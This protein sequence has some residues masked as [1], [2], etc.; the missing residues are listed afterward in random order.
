MYAQS[1][2]TIGSGTSLDIGN[3]TMNVDD[4]DIDGTL[5]GDTGTI[6]VK[7][8]WTN[9]GTFT[10]GT[11]DVNLIDDP[12]QSPTQ[13][14]VTITGNSQF[15]DLSAITG[16]GKEF[17]FGASETQTVTNNITLLGA[18]TPNLLMRST[19]SGEFAF[20]NLLAGGTQSIDLVDVNDHLATGLELSPLPGTN[21]TAGNVSRWL[22]VNSG[23][24]VWINPAG[25]SWHTASNWS[26]NVVPTIVDD[27][28]IPD[29]G[30]IT[31]TYSTG[32]TSINSLST[33]DNV[34]I[35]GGTLNLAAASTIGTGATLA[36]SGG[37]ING[38]GDLTVDGTLNWTLGTMTGTGTT[39]IQIGANLAI[40]GS[41]SKDLAGTRRLINDS[42]TSTM[43][44]PNNTTGNVRMFDAAVFDNQGS[45]VV[46]T[47][48]SDSIVFQGIS[49]T[50]SFDN[51]GTFTRSAG[52][53]EATFSVAFNNTG[54]VDVQT[55]ILRLAGG[56]SSSGSLSGA[57]L[58]IDTVAYTLDAGV[59]FQDIVFS[60]FATVNINS[61]YTATVSTLV[62]IGATVNFNNGS[63][64]ADIG[65]SL[66][67]TGIPQPLVNFSSGSPTPAT[68]TT[69]VI[70]LSGGV[71]TGSDNLSILAGAGNVFTWTLGTM[72]GTGTTTIPIG[73]NLA[74]SGN[75]SKDLAGARR[76]INNSTTSTMDMPNNTTGNVRMF[77]TAVFDNQGSLVVT[78]T[79]SDSIVFLG[80]SGSPSFDNSGTFTRSAGNGEATFSVSFNN[81]GT[82][83]AQEGT[84]KF[85]GAF[86]NLDGA[87]L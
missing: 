8:D 62:G 41:S 29:F 25:G 32:T 47:T 75:S 73:A 45:L 38:S 22:G 56:G 66:T 42:A 26:S 15:Y 44:M 33:S 31:V 27:V 46:T 48:D 54:T 65:G 77:D 36:L 10:A 63:T 49:G 5:D 52:N 19:A 85:D 23:A 11:G 83:D 24:V 68:I 80:M 18:S 13:S 57:G 74:I 51:S 20:I 59:S 82:V 69:D 7:G 72:S 58:Q 61:S 1:S 40:S 30:G 9:N 60:N 84:L 43:D 81:T 4:V 55:G 12:A 64:I 39:T 6:N 34:S 87:I 53:G 86:R 28:V 78:T 35:T 2:L 76:L 14:A 21:V 67:L 16:D 37:T 70:T 79:D 17:R 50:P 71:I 3:S